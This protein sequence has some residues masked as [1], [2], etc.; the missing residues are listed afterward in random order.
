MR[1]QCTSIPEIP[2]R[3]F[4]D[5]IHR[6]VEKTRIP[7]SGEIELT[8][9]CNLA[10]AHCYNRGVGSVENR[11]P[12][13]GESC[14]DGELSAGDFSGII[15]QLVDAGCLW[16][17]LTGG[18]PLVRD[19][20]REI[21]LYAKK[22]G[23]LLTLFTNGTLISEEM[24][25]FLTEWPPLGIEISLYGA[26]KDTYERVTG[27][28]GSYNRCMQGINRLLERGLPL[29]LKTLVS[30]LNR[31]ELDSMKAFARSRGV[32]FRYD[33]IINPRLDGDRT[34]C[35]YRLS[36]EEVVEFDMNDPERCR[37]WIEL[38]DEFHG[39][40][41]TSRKYPCG[42]GVY[43]FHIDPLGKLNLCGMSRIPAYDLTS[44]SFRTGWEEV[45]PGIISAEGNP[46]FTCRT[47]PLLLLCGQC[48]SLS[49]MENGQE[50]MPIDYFCRIAHIRAERFGF[51]YMERKCSDESK[52]T[53]HIS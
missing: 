36:P 49:L 31:H 4:S 50:E 32:K 15:D 24:A 45:M 29:E 27:V 26:S 37:S 13:H 23:I 52:E 25:D 21:Y 34:P 30:S 39:T 42:G 40:F 33:L 11:P 20:F 16:L 47:C 18:E 7:I 41:D 53:L 17:L 46:D 19:D 5:S 2:Y 14:D 44:G 10:C 48:P 43:S 38:W 8:R 6:N 1:R 51:T 12:E 35:R 9:R 28:E 22:S 3:S